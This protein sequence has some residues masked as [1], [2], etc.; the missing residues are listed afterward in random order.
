MERHL[1]LLRFPPYRHQGHNR[2]QVQ[3]RLALP[4][5][6]RVRDWLPAAIAYRGLRL[7]DLLRGITRKPRSDRAAPTP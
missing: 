4:L 3:W 2:I 5:L 6:D 7:L 1:D